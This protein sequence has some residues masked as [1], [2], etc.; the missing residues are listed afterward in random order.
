MNQTL[1]FKTL[2]TFFSVEAYVKQIAKESSFEN[3][4]LFFYLVFA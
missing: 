2:K 3:T 4:G 1:K